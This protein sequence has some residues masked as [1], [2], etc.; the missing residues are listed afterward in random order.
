MKKKRLCLFLGIV[1]S[2]AIIFI[3]FRAVSRQA[4]F[5][6][7]PC[8]QLK[9][10]ENWKCREHEERGAD[11]VILFF[12][13]EACGDIS[14]YRYEKYTADTDYEKQVRTMW[15]GMHIYVKE[16]DTGWMEQDGFLFKRLLLGRELSAAE[17]IQGHEEYSDEAHYYVF[18]E[19]GCFIDI[20]LDEGIVTEE[21]ARELIRG[22]TFRGEETGS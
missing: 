3:I 13:N 17:E 6:K 5:Y 20:R 1:I 10:P 11:L 12:N 9:L 18:I 15:G 2:A 22:M 21:M 4:S 8:Y 19:D 14:V 16:S 7:N